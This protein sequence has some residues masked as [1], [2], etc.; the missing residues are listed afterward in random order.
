[1][2]DEN[3][4]K[5]AAAASREVIDISEQ[6]PDANLRLYRNNENGDGEFNPYKSCV[7]VHLIN[8]N[9]EIIFARS[10][11][12]NTQAW[13]I[14]CFPGPKTL[15]G[16]GATQR[17]VDAFL[18][19]N[20][21]PIEDPNSGYVEDGFATQPGQ[22]WNPNNRAVDTEEGRIQMISDIRQSTAWGHWAGEWNMYA[23]REPR[24]YASIIYNKRIIPSLP[25]DIEKRN[26]YNTAGQQDGYARA[27]L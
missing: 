18:M 6:H 12:S 21:K 23:N 27:E 17:V 16:V 20:G 4:W 10:E 24:F 13:M 3:K 9:C 15:G 14:H 2:Y 26:Y 19:E 11:S 5:K 22:H 7:D 1:M 8:W 25:D